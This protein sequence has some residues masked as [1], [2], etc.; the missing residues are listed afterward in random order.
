VFLPVRCCVLGS[1]IHAQIFPPKQWDK[2]FGGTDDDVLQT[3]QTTKDGGYIL[4]GYSYSIA[5]GNKSESTHGVN[6]FWVVKINSKGTKQWEKS[7][8]GTG[9][10]EMYSLQKTKDG[11]YI[12]GGYS[13]SDIGGDKTQASR[14]GNDYWIVKIDGS[15]NKQ[16]DKC[17]WRFLR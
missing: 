14:G 8:G 9:D 10:D 16:W 17:L 7:Y 6:D 2:D 3:L 11:G 15:G 5:S 1:L 4:G 12:L 13:N